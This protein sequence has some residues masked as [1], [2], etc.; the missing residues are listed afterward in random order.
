MEFI[1]FLLLLIG[2]IPVKLDI[3]TKKKVYKVPAH[4]FCNLI[5]IAIIVLGGL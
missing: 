3:P 2:F 5:A 4:V 1:V